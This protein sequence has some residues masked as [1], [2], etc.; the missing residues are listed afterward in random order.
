MELC[1]SYSR[2]GGWTYARIG[3]MSAFLVAV[4][5]LK[6]SS[7]KLASGVISVRGTT[8]LQLHTRVQHNSPGRGL[9]QRHPAESPQTASV[10]SDF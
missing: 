6:V 10:W 8:T 4:I 2:P 3:S 5:I 9:T 1:V 7:V